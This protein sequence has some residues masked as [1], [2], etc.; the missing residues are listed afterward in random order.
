MITESITNFINTHTDLIIWGSITLLLI[1][2]A[3]VIFEVIKHT[4]E[5]RKFQRNLQSENI[6]RYASEYG[7]IGEIINIDGDEVTILLKVPREDLLRP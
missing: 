2:L 5:L 4:K 1:V 3:S 6:I 7:A